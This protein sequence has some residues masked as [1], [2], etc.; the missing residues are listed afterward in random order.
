MKRKK[1]TYAD[2]MRIACELEKRLCWAVKFMRPPS[3]NSLVVHC[4][5]DG[6]FGKSEHWSGWFA[7]GIEM[8]GLRKVDRELIGLSQKEFKAVLKRREIE[9]K[10]G[11]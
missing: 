9:K 8:L 1:H 7:D 6:N 3:A 5:K 2:L 10:G 4:D 11:A